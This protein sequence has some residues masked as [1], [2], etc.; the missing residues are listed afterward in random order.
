MT[1]SKAYDAAKV[2]LTLMVVFAHASRMY[3]GGVYSPINSSSLLQMLTAVIYAFHMP[4]F[5]LLS[6]C[7]FGYQIDN[8]KYTKHG[9]FLIEKFRSLIIPYLFI[10]LLFV[11]PTMIFLGLTELSFLQYIWHGILLCKNNRHLWYILVLFCIFALTIPLRKLL[12]SKR[13]WFGIVLLAVSLLFSSIGVFAKRL[14]IWSVLYYLPFFIC[15]IY[16]N[17]YW[18]S[19]F[20][21][22][23]RVLIVICFILCMLILALRVF[24]Y[25]RF[26]YYVFATAGCLA[27]FCF[28]SL[29]PAAVGDWKPLRAL[30]RYS[31]G[32]YLFHPMLIYLIFACTWY[33]DISPW[34]LCSSAFVLS[35]TASIPITAVIRKL[36]LG[37]LLGEKT[38]LPNRIK[39][40]SNNLQ[41]WIGNYPSNKGRYHPVNHY[42]TLKNK[43]RRQYIFPGDRLSLWLAKL[44][45]SDTYDIYRF[46]LH[47]RQYEH[48]ITC[49][50]TLFMKFRR[51]WH[52]RQYQKYAKGLGYVIGDGVLGENVVFFH[53]GSI[54]INPNARIGPNCKF[55]GDCSIGV[56]HTGST[57]SPRLGKGVDI[58][59]GACI[60]GDV[61]IADDIVIGANS[62][63]ISSFYEPGITIA[64][65]PARKIREAEKKDE[66]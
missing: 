52:L 1:K 60:L 45:C 31:Y 13:I 56:A 11:A 55:H 48:L 38:K 59:I 42:R 16:L 30:L 46:L 58:G 41:D 2:I 19:I 51:L 25:S 47:L 36:H 22:K 15:G 9:F 37:I 12:L 57:A 39:S 64:G 24:V 28:I 10:G 29:L 18:D 61:Y 40:R 32:I 17:R 49:K 66:A 44:T 20:A 7:I 21:K 54:V 8:G 50:T 26:L 27:L 33:R 3:A 65:V 43:L 4:A 35:T 63:V 23:H 62:V 5:F 6:G 14:P 53:R 34:L